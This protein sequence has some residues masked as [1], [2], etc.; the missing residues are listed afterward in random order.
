M[1]KTKIVVIDD[2]PDLL[3]AVDKK[4]TSE[5]F[6]VTVAVDGNSGLEAISR[7]QPDLIVL[8]L[9][10]PDID[11]FNICRQVR[12]SSNV[13]IL[14][15]TAKG[16][17]ANQVMGLELGADDYV[18]KP[19]SPRA[20]T[21]RIRA[22]L[23]RRAAVSAT[24]LPLPVGTIAPQAIDDEIWVDSLAEDQTRASASPE[25]APE[26]VG[27]AITLASHGDFWRIN[28]RWHMLREAEVP[29]NEMQLK[30]NSMGIVAAGHIVEILG[31]ADWIGV[32]KE[33]YLY[34]ATTIE[35]VDEPIA[36]GHLLT[37]ACRNAELL[38]EGRRL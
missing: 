10:L 20:L 33:V 7:V 11:G 13:L 26:A 12:E 30:R 3:D 32:V 38:Q 2:D 18:T 29:A 35:E 21:A 16:E 22:L 6:Q 19:F 14:I 4:L 34:K 28:Q 5:G 1:A 15:L 23:R 31:D 24:G 27:S 25:P 17:E 9:M 8:D 36:H 37:N